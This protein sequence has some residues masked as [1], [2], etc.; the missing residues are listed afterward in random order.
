MFGIRED[1]ELSDVPFATRAHE[2]GLWEALSRLVAQISLEWRREEVQGSC[3]C[4]GRE[5]DS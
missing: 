3:G 4:L 5:E 1:S 2:D